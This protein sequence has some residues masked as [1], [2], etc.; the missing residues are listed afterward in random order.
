MQTHGA[1]G[2]KLQGK[3]QEGDEID[4]SPFGYIFQVVIY[5]VPL[6]AIHHDLIVA[7]ETRESINYGFKA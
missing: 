7:F 1:E 3:Q 5:C 4:Q 2:M 6:G